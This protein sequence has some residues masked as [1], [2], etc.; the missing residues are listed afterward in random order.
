MLKTSSTFLSVLIA[1]CFFSTSVFAQPTWTLDPFGK[2]KKPEQ[3]EEKKLASEKTGDSKFG[4]FRRIVQNT[5][6]HYNYYFNGN[7]KIKAVVERARLSAKDDYSKLLSFYPYSFEATAA[8]QGDLDSV[9]YKATAGIL[10]HDLRSDWVDNMYLLIG[11]AYYYRNELDSA[12]LT[13]QFINYNL[14]PRKKNEDDSRVVGTNDAPGA[15]NLSIANKENPNFL[16]KVFSLPPSRNDALVWLART[17]TAQGAYGDAAGLINILQSDKNLPNRLRS[18]LDEVTAYWFFAQQNYD[19]A[20]SHLALALDNALDMQDRSRWEYLLA[21]ML[22]MRGKYDEAS[23]YYQRASKHTTDL[24]LDINARL[25]QAKMLRDDADL[26]ALN[27]SIENL[28]RMAR[29]DRFENYRDILYYSAAQLTMKRPDTANSFVYLTRAAAFNKGNLPYRN[30]T[31]FQLGNLSYVQGHYKAAASFYDSLEVAADDE[32]INA[33][34]LNE[35]KEGLGKMVRFINNVEREDSL[36]RIAAMSPAERDAF[37]KK[38]LRRLRKEKGMKE[39]DFS[40]GNQPITF[41]NNKQESTDLFESNAKGEWYFYNNNVRN[42]G[43]ADFI[44]KW[45]KRENVDNWRLKEAGAGNMNAGPGGDPGIGVIAADTAGSLVPMTFDALMADIPLTAEAMDSSN[46]IIAS[47]MLAIA[48]ILQEDLQEY[49]AAIA[50]YEDFLSAFPDDLSVSEA[51]LGLYFCYSK[52][53]ELAKAQYYKNMLT[54][55][56]AGSRAA[57]LIQNPSLLNPNA[58]TPELTAKYENIY[59]LFIE[60]RFDEAVAEKAKAD[61]VSGS[62]YWSP[63]LLYIEAVHYIKTQ[64]DSSAIAV[65]QKLQSLYPGSPMAPKAAT[66]AD[67]LGRR[68]EIEQ[69]LTKLEVTRAEEPRIVVSDDKPKQQTS[70]IAPT[71]VAPAKVQATVQPL[72]VRDTTAIKPVGEAASF[73]IRPE[74]KHFVVMLLDKVDYTYINEAKNAFTRYN[75]SS[76]LTQNIKVDRDTIDAQ[77]TILLFSNFEDAET[78]LKYFDKVKKAAPDEVS[79]LPANKYSFFIISED[80]LQLLKTNKDLEGYRKLLNGIFG[81]RF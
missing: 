30:K 53:G 76:Y 68:S 81:N 69:Y 25:N 70:N 63:Q 36:Q 52:T 24:V 22:E 40:G 64:Q 33:A 7:N 47:S 26:A 74:L 2:E 62:N 51:L 8:Q 3:Y 75:R 12:A 35:R 18:D 34:E 54:S 61:S 67:V 49:P 20:A 38:L 57:T 11:K 41:N 78:A 77:R 21:Q 45:G 32:T 31:Y 60:G 73:S 10:L 9:I 46:R 19:S 50:K 16:Q 27:R 4:T 39:E 79:W 72:K 58:K 15:G 56:H 55:K 23:N 28:I 37:V 65:L 59:N 13:F 44:R 80:N 71:A 29:K 66:L 14:F 42:K 17:F 5:T 1:G 48:K 6:T 43:L